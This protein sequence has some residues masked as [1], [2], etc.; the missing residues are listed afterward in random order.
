MSTD[1][2]SGDEKA[3]TLNGRSAYGFRQAVRACKAA[4]NGLCKSFNI[5]KK[6]F[7]RGYT[8]DFFDTVLD[9]EN[10]HGEAGLGG[11]LPTTYMKYKYGDCHMAAPNTTQTCCNEDLVM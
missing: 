5:R 7:G 1:E 6:E 11:A 2:V 3:I 8:C 9:G 4:C 10:C